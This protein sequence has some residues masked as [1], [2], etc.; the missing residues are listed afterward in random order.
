MVKKVHH[1]LVKKI[2]KI[3]YQ[4]WIHNMIYLILIKLIINPM[5][6]NNIEVAI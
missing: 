6:K 3:K 4:E 5:A 2:S 1:H